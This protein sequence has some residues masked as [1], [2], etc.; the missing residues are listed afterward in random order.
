MLPF[1]W[2]K[3]QILKSLPPKETVNL[4]STDLFIPSKCFFSIFFV[5]LSSRGLSRAKPFRKCYHSPF[6]KDPSLKSHFQCYSKVPST[7][8][9]FSHQ[10]F[11]EKP[12]QCEPPQKV[13]GMKNVYITLGINLLNLLRNKHKICSHSDVVN[14]NFNFYLWGS[15]L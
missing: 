14:R 8:I 3:R 6:I 5:C 2:L 10:S 4:A 11:P 15:N 1:H 9:G 13:F 7:R 12:E